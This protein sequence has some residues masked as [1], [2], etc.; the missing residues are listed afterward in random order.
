[1]CDACVGEFGKVDVVVAAAGITKRVPTLDM[2]EADW[3][4]IID[5]NLNGMMRTFQI[6]GKA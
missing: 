5:T 2:T 1:M 6:F 3:N 4:S